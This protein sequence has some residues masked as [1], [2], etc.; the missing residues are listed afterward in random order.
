MTFPVSVAGAAL[1][2]GAIYAFAS[3]ETGAGTVAGTL[4][5][6]T[7]SAIAEAFPVPIEGVAAG[8]TSLANIFIV[9]AAVIYGWAA[10][11]IVGFVAMGAVELAHRRRLDRLLFNT[12]LYALAAGAAGGL[13]ATVN[14]HS[15]AYRLLA[16]ALASS[17]FYFVDITLLSGVIAEASARP[18][19]SVYGRSM[20]STV[21]PF[22]IMMSL[23]AILIVLWD[24]SPYIAVALTG[25][26]VAIA[27]YERRVHTILERLRELDRI[28][29]E[30]IAVVS[31][32]LR[33][34]ISSVY[35]AATTLQRRNLD[36]ARRDSLL[37]VIYAESARL[38]RLVDQVVW[39]S[40]F[41]SGH[42]SIAVEPCRPAEL[43]NEVIEAARFH[44]P[45]SVTIE[46]RADSALPN[47]LADPERVRQVLVNLLDNAVKFSPEG[48]SIE[49]ALE[50]SDGNVRFAVADEGLGIPAEEQGRIFEKFHRLDPNLTRG[51]GGTGLGLYIC[52][53]LIREMNGRIW[54]T[55]REREGST[56]TFE[57]PVA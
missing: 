3:G 28:K 37:S 20:Y 10:A 17:A 4:A 52:Q 35:G 44:L 12:G 21:V 33:T 25:P 47:V 18:F 1:F 48:G 42:V 55:S 15:L 2:V 22:A 19:V 39:A 16:A 53:E 23:A 13:A 31:H 46:L 34:P 43:A 7:A 51:I 11:S 24:R 30:F 50:V 29:N 8:R 14:G 36:R 49:V 26:L 41:E 54:V 40:R 27:L 38:A 56:F 9:G 5:L 32:E 6:L 57:L 45:E